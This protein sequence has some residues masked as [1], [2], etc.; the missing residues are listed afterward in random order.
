M[1]DSAIRTK[2]MNENTAVSRRLFVIKPRE[3]WELPDRVVEIPSPSRL[4]AAPAPL[5]M[6]AMVLPPILMLVAVGVHRVSIRS[7]IL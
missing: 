1:V 2:K 5:N 7:F 6:L 4:P 3:P